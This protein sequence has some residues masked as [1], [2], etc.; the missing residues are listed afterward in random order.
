PPAH[1]GL[2]RRAGVRNSPFV[3]D[4]GAARPARGWFLSLTYSQES[5]T[6]LNAAWS[7]RG[8]GGRSLKV[9]DLLRLL[10]KDGWES[11]R[12][13]GQASPART[14]NQVGHGYGL[15]PFE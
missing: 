8:R 4:S 14:S 3:R 11:D 13:R 6:T 12:T 15:R 10:K 1:P 9:R 7:G 5:I 2:F